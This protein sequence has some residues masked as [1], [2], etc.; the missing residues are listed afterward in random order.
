MIERGMWGRATA[1]SPV[2]GPPLKCKTCGAT[3]VYWQRVRKQHNRAGYLLHDIATLKPHSCP[4]PPN[5][6]DGFEDC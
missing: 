5:T 4:I 2:Y 6:P 3:N 1:R